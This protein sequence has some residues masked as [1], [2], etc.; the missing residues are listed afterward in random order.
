MKLGE[1]HQR[2]TGRKRQPPVWRSDL[3]S[4]T[5]EQATA[6]QP[7]GLRGRAAMLSAIAVDSV[8]S[9]VAWSAKV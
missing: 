3:L 4:V 8:S 6:L 1:F 5:R 2:W 7:S 9:V